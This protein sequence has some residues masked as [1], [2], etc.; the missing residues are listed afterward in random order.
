[1]FLSFAGA[2]T[3]LV[4]TRFSLRSSV[5]C[6]LRATSNFQSSGFQHGYWTRTGCPYGLPS[7]VTLC[8]SIRV[9]RPSAQAL[10]SSNSGWGRP[11]PGVQVGCLAFTVRLPS[12]ALA[13]NPDYRYNATLRT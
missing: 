4:E 1:M 12:E 8:F 13:R 2:L 11:Q 5:N 7:G 6:E 3:F 10:I 9:I